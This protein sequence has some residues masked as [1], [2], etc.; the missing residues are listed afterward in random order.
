MIR[1]SSIQ[2]V[3]VIAVVGLTLIAVAGFASTVAGWAFMSSAVLGVV[4]S[5]LVA[6]GARRFELLL[7][8]AIACSI[9][10]F[11]LL[12]G[13]A[14]GGV[15]SP[16]GYI[17][18]AD[19]LLNGWS[20]FLSS[21]AP[22]DL[23]A[24]FRVLP[25]AIAWW[26]VVAGL[27][28]LRRSTHP[29]V[30]MGG[31]LAGLM[32]TSLLTVGDA[33]LAQVQGL[34]MVVGALI[35]VGQRTPRGT[36]SN[37]LTALVML[38]VVVGAAPVLGPHLPLA[39]ANERFDLRQ[40]Q[41]RPWNPLDQ[42][43]PLATLKASLKEPRSD[44][45]V[46]TV[47][48]PDPIN[49]WSL[50]VL[51]DY[52]GVVWAVADETAGAAAQFE[53]VDTRLPSSGQPA[54]AQPV[55]AYELEVGDLGGVWI[56][57][58]GWPNRAESDVPLRMNTSTGTLASPAG[59]EP[60]SS[61]QMWSTP[62]PELPLAEVLDSTVPEFDESAELA[63]LP[64]RIRNLAG[65]VFEGVEH[66]PNRAT[67]VSNRFS[68]TGFYDAGPSAR[69]GHSLARID[70]FLTDPERLVGY[71]EQYAATA[72]LLLRSAGI[73]TRVVVGY[74]VPETRFDNGVID[75]RAGDISAWIEILT[76][77]HGWVPLTVS[78]DRARIP[79]Q[80]TT[81]SAVQDIV[82][83]NPPTPPPP[84]AD[85][86]QPTSRSDDLDDDED[87]RRDEQ[88]SIIRSV[89]VPVVVTGLA[90]GTPTI[91]LGTAGLLVVGM[92]YRRRQRR[93][94][95]GPAEHR[96]AGAW[97]ELVDR[98]HELGVVTSGPATPSEAVRAYATAIPIEPEVELE[99]VRLAEAL[100]RS[101]FHPDAPGPEQVSA[102]WASTDRV[103]SHLRSTRSR[104]ERVVAAT[105]PRPLL[106]TDKHRPVNAQVEDEEHPAPKEFT[107]T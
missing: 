20:D 10:A 34:S 88:P 68:T 90:L 21:A 61:I 95:T 28:T 53:P 74:L 89:P 36:R 63:L 46:F 105:D 107:T 70:E 78:P 11:V 52:N 81:G 49:R 17:R 69:P 76:L 48:S 77:E 45:V 101:S 73:P 23:S 30:P 26:S 9:V 60:G 72:A 103:V 96:V 43:S 27:E 67:E 97:R 102:A 39:T 2:T 66:G 62:R 18:F 41:D 85:L 42:P 31:P 1:R 86:D 75:V 22:V 54:S 4:G 91:G 71:E 56:P 65:D 13:A 12:G 51:G 3:P 64:P 98:Y 14:T 106:R 44:D 37:R 94:L 57:T 35:L 19:G 38:L 59:L 79:E 58:A 7:G 25:F 15:P 32:V 40:L 104:W 100:D 29:L 8:E 33:R 93:Q 92:K 5:F 82:I 87:D 83:P 24:E 99:L 16:A 47:R 80:E 50:A 55:F 6:T 84:P